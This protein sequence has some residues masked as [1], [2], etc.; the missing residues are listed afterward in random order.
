ML[1]C[2]TIIGIPL[3]KMCN[4]HF[5]GA[6]A[7]ILMKNIAYV[8]V[9]C[10]LLDIDRAIVKQL[11]EETFASKPKLVD[12]NLEAI[13]LGYEYATDNF[14]CPLPVRAETM[15]DNSKHIL[16]DGNS[17]AALGWG[18]A[19][20]SPR[21]SLSPGPVSSSTAAGGAKRQRLRSSATFASSSMALQKSCRSGRRPACTA[22]FRFSRQVRG[23]AVRSR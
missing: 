3:S 15:G 11:L 6:R 14:T 23:V 21:S 16:I 2:L 1:L 22:A 13:N 12:S 17:A 20:S 9:L 7:R 4:E 5:D 18:R 8:G 19:S 10:A